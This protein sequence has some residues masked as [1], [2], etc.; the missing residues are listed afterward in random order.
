VSTLAITIRASIVRISIP[1]PT[2]FGG[3]LRLAQLREAIEAVQNLSTWGPRPLDLAQQHFGVFDYLLGRAHCRFNAIQVVG[4]RVV[5]LPDPIKEKL[6]VRFAQR[7]ASHLYLLQVETV[8][9]P[10][11]RRRCGKHTTPTR[12]AAPSPGSGWS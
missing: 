12:L 7:R 6:H 10:V 2:S 11:P 1:M 3:C 5:L 9:A 4:V 8:R